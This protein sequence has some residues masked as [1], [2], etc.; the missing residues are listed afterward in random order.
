MASDPFTE[1]RVGVFRRMLIG[2][3]LRR[4]LIRAALLA[5]VCVLVFRFVLAPLRLDGE[6]MEPTFQ[7]GGFAL[8]NRLAYL[9]AAP[10]RGDVVAV[11]LRDSG[12]S[13]FYLKRVVGL[14]G[15]SI[16]FH[17][18]QLTVDG[19]PHKEPYLI[20]QS[21]W[22][23]DPV[24]CGPQEYFVVGDNRSMSIENHTFGRTYQSR[25]VGKVIF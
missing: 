1:P 11:R 10:Q 9:S 15:E 2:R 13:I 5:G 20:Y 18:G 22:N 25:I 12:R 8:A 4:T 21:D 14:P 17:D 16:G 7:S 24:V 23:R 19:V 6:S 3:S